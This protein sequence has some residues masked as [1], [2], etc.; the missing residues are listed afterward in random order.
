MSILSRIT[1]CK[2]FVLDKRIE[3]WPEIETAW[4]KKGI[5]VDRVLMGD[6]S[7]SEKYDYIDTNELPPVYINSLHSLTW[8]NCPA[9]YNF[10]KVQRQVLQEF[11]DNNGEYL[12]H[13]E[14]DHEICS[15]FDSILVDTEP[16]LDKLEINIL[17]FGSFHYPGSNLETSHPNIL[18]LCGSG[19]L[20][21]AILSRE[22][23]VDLLNA[24]PTGPMDYQLG[25]NHHRYKAYC[26]YP[27]IVLQKSGYSY[28]ERVEQVKPSRWTK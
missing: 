18:R 28:V 1:H 2:C 24:G 27:A 10:Y 25:L 3:Y 15:D 6:G 9:A 7:L 23:C 14:D 4:A 11:V 26:F 21:S 8:K 22:V 19:G 16:F 12:L 20:H 5:K 13:L 17:S